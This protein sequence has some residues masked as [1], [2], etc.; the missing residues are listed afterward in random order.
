[1]LRTSSANS[2]VAPEKIECGFIDNSKVN[3][4]MSG[5]KLFLLMLPPL[6]FLLILKTSSRKNPH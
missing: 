4:I 3:G 2:R 1:M 5:E 6:S